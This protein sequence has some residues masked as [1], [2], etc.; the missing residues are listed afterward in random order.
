MLE[1][2]TI[3]KTGWSSIIVHIGVLNSEGASLRRVQE[4]SIV[5]S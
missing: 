4:N 3:G 5:V 2:K 1:G